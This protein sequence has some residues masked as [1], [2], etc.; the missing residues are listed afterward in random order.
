MPAQER[1]ILLWVRDLTKKTV[2]QNLSTK[3][4]QQR[5][6]IGHAKNYFAFFYS[7][8][9]KKDY[10]RTFS[11]VEALFLV[12]VPALLLLERVDQPAEVSA[13]LLDVLVMWRVFRVLA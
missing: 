9:N 10:M 3:K 13:A 2:S 1:E 12:F 6:Q 4:F 8:D 11:F 7:E 5:C